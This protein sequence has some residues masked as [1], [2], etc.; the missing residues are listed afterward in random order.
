MKLT[1]VYFCISNTDQV[2]DYFLFYICAKF[3]CVLNFEAKYDLQR[4]TT[5]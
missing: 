1:V 2:K 4:I 3:R 5:A